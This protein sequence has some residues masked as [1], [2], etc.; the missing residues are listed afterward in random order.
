MR[1]REGKPL[2]PRILLFIGIVAAT[3]VAVPWYLAEAHA[4]REQTLRAQLFS[5]RAAIDQYYG[6]K[7]RYPASLDELV[8]AH[9]LRLVPR[10]PLTGRSDSWRVTETTADGNTGIYDVHSGASGQGQDGT[11]YGDW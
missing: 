2:L 11:A 3:T 10:D 9:Y 1:P 4:G 7:N 6:E 5:L 8:T